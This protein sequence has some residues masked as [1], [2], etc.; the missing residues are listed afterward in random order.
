MKKGYWIVAYRAVFNS[1]AFGGL[2]R[3]GGRVLARG[4]AVGVHEARV[5]ERTVRFFPRRHPI[6]VL[7]STFGCRTMCS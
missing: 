3:A 7:T 1:A 2:F 4:K 5:N 6:L